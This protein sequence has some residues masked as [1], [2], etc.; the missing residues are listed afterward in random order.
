MISN[1]Q[2]I[3]DKSESKAEKRR[4]I[5][6]AIYKYVFKDIGTNS[7]LAQKIEYPMGLL[8]VSFLPLLG[9][10]Q[11]L[12][13]PNNYHQFPK[14]YPLPIEEIPEEILEHSRFLEPEDLPTL[15]K[16]IETYFRIKESTSP[17]RRESFDSRKY[18]TR[19]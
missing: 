9:G 5:S 1:L 15:H 18:G 11:G 17:Q 8:E 6:D 7:F 13:G 3:I 4:K 12:R 10:S 16:F 19:E 14:Y 2:D